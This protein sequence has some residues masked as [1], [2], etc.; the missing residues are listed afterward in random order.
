LRHYDQ[1][2]ARRKHLS[3]VRKF[4]GVKP[5]SAQGKILLHTTLSEAALTK[6]DI[7]DLVNVGIETLVRHQ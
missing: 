6:E 7:A 5:F 2:E 3:V 4:L 1:S